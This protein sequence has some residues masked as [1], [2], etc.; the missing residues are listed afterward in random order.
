MPR[1]SSRRAGA[2]TSCSSAACATACRRYSASCPP[3][4]VRSSIRSSARIRRRSRRAS[5]CG[6]SRRWTS[7]ERVTRS[8]ARASSQRPRR[9]AG[10]CSSSPS[11]RTS[12]PRTWRTSRGRSRRRSRDGPRGAIRS[13]L[14]AR[15]APPRRAPRRVVGAIRRGGGAVAVPLLG[16]AR[17]VVARLR[18]AA[19]AL[20]PR[21]ARR[22]G[23][24][25]GAPPPRRRRGAARAAALAPAR[26]RRHRRRRARRAR[27]RRGRVGGARGALSR[28]PRRLRGVGRP[29]PRGPPLRFAHGR[30]A[31]ASHG[32]AR[33]E[34]A[35]R[36]R[37]RLSRLR[38]ARDIR[39]A[40]RARPAPRD[41]RPPRPLAHPPA[42]L[43]DR[44]RD[45]A[46]RGAGGA[47]G[48]PAPPPAPLGGRGRSAGIPQGA[49]EDFHREAAPRLAKRGW[50]RLYRL[51]VGGAAVAAVYGLEVRRRFFYYQSGY[52][53]AW[54]PRSPG[55]VLV[56]RTIE[57]A[58]GCGLSDYDFLRGTE[59]YKL[60]WASDRHETCTIRLRAP[61]LR[62]G[63]AALAREAWRGARDAARAIAPARAWEALRRARRGFESRSLAGARTGGGEP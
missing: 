18:R 32:R 25:R 1:R 41:L 62:A 52:D 12:P 53:P 17:R 16:V 40:P 26:E 37:L 6:E 57:D 28:A 13:P 8:A 59:P 10:A 15:P 9:S 39:G 50:L 21:G 23:Q 46:R 35:R 27:P 48:P 14:V 47:R 60:E 36:A 11:T 63:T 5:R 33:R 58:Y 61:S 51:H 54:A 38:A 55:L 34:R 3:G 31:P 22:R 30:G 29:R 7:G 43:Q 49:V 45:D 19:R 56:G 44:R 20:D 2:T 4:R 42:R 24:P